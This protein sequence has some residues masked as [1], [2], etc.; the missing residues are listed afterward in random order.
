MTTLKF[1]KGYYKLAISDFLSNY[2]TTVASTTI[3]LWLLNSL[4][5]GFE[6]SNRFLTIYLTLAAASELVTGLFSGA[7]ADRFG[8]LKTA[9]FACIS[10]II[11]GLLIIS[12]VFISGTSHALPVN[13]AFWIVSLLVVIT[14]GC[15]TFYFP[16]LTSFVN[17]ITEANKLINVLSLLRFTSLMGDLVGPAVAGFAHSQYAYIAILATESLALTIAVACIALSA[18][19]YKGSINSTNTAESQSKNSFFSDWFH[20]L[21]IFVKNKT[22]QVLAPFALL[23]AVASSGINFSIILLF[24]NV[25]HDTESYGLFLSMMSLGY[26]LSYLVS[27]KLS[28][29]FSFW[30]MLTGSHV[31][32]TITLILLAFT[33]NGKIAILLGFLLAFFQGIINPPFQALFVHAVDE[34]VVAQVM[35]VFISVVAAVGS[36]SYPLWDSIYSIQRLPT[37]PE[38]IIIFSAA[39][40]HSILV[41]LCFTIKRIRNLSDKTDREFLE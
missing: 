4:L 16:A 3:K 32:V 9:I 39:I 10:R 5:T 27:A 26:A 31:L 38:V 17:R 28:K 29:R 23:E 19:A 21:A 25:L 18:K 24:T 14:T 40:L 2:A 20:G 37:H 22:Y 7:I 6:N 35:S 36:I 30:Q 41:L 1:L 15:D 8:A 33:P 13:T 12:I 34:T 11:A